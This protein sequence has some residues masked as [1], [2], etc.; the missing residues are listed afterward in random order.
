MLLKCVLCFVCTF[1]CVCKGFVFMERVVY[2]CVIC[3]WCVCVSDTCMSD[4]C[5]MCMNIYQDTVQ[6]CIHTGTYIQFPFR[7]SS[8]VT[9]PRKLSS[10]PSLLWLGQGPVL[11]S[12]LL[13]LSSF[14]STYQMTMEYAKF[15]WVYW[16]TQWAPGKWAGP[17]RTYKS[18]LYLL[19]ASSVGWRKTNRQASTEFSTIQGMAKIRAHLGLNCFLVWLF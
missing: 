12:P 6:A 9:V 18:V 8:E 13:K 7:L 10:M 11:E 19:Y 16:P 5:V 17:G 14:D 2:V 3:M 4:V 15:I 1:A